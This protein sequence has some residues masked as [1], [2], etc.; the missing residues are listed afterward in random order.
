MMNDNTT[1]M[2]A[3]EYD[4]KINNTIPYYNEFYTQTLD[5]IA[6]CGYSELDWLDLGCGTGTLEEK[7]LRV[8]PSARFVAVDPSE[9]MLEQAGNKLSGY[10]IEFVT[11]KS[12]EINYTNRFDVVT[13]IQ[14]HHYMHEEERQRSITRVYDALRD[15]GIF[16][17][18]E[19]V[20]PE[21]ET[22]KKQELLRWG[23]YQQRHGK[24]EAEALEHNA[25]CGTG[26]FPI[27]VPQH[28]QLL[29]SVGFTDVH[30]FWL[31][32]MQMGIYA[33]RK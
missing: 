31:S 20:V 1:P 29:K 7:A 22:V 33:F 26:Y 24:T 14:S 15:G 25:R 12:S 16:I 32:Y 11:G 23:R 3:A 28:I 10:N 2:A 5:V 6:Q 30:V 8:F 21:S 27:T 9:K 18:F 13:A 4:R 19:N 17:C